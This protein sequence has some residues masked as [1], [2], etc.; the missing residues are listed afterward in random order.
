MILLIMTF[1][2]IFTL[3]SV[4]IFPVEKPISI[5]EVSTLPNDLTHR[6]LDSEMGI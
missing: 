5:L 3:V 2:L 6:V 1:L 4:V